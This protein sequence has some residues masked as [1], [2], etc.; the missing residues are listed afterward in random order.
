MSTNRPHK[1]KIMNLFWK[2]KLEWHIFQQYFSPPRHPWN[3]ARAKPPWVSSTPIIH[4]NS[5]IT[6]SICFQSYWYIKKYADSGTRTKIVLT[7]VQLPRLHKKNDDS[8]TRTN[9]VCFQR[10]L[11]ARVELSGLCL[12]TIRM[13]GPVDSSI[14]SRKASLARG[15]VNVI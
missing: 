8:G 10:L 3:K 7:S 15:R 6:I 2:P 5:R 4:A 11:L 14:L 13:N 12:L 1:R 9:I